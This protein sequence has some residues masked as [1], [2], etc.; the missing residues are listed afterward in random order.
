M[1][2]KKTH[3][4]QSAGHKMIFGYTV[5]TT[6]LRLS[7]DFVLKTIQ[8]FW[9][10]LYFIAP[11]LI[12]LPMSTELL[13]HRKVQGQDPCPGCILNVMRKGKNN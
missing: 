1:R 11:V 4:L 2:V 7:F 6:K 12:I 10:D 9:Y 8:I 13:T 5:S 3:F